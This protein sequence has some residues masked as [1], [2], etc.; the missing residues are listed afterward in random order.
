MAEVRSLS[1]FMPTAVGPLRVCGILVTLEESPT[2]CVATFNCSFQSEGQGT[3]LLGEG[4]KKEKLLVIKIIRGSE[5]Y[6]TSNIVCN[7]VI[8]TFG[9]R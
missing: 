1:T 8:T 7:V 5:K 6:S 3:L 2:A 4:V 9:A